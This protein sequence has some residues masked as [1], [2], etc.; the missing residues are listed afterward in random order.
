MNQL[1]IRNE[2]LEIGGGARMM[3]EHKKKSVGRDALIPPWKNLNNRPQLKKRFLF[4]RFL[5][6]LLKTSNPSGLPYAHP[7]Q[8]H[9][10]KSV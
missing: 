10:S 4:P 6:H 2:K 5:P 7:A 8:M 1:G 3:A 9:P